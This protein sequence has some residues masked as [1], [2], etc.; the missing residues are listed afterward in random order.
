MYTTEFCWHAL[1]RYLRSVGFNRTFMFGA[2]T[3]RPFASLCLLCARAW[4]ETKENRKEE[5][6]RPA[7]RG[8]AW[9]KVGGSRKG[10][11]HAPYRLTSGI[12]C[13]FEGLHFGVCAMFIQHFIKGQQ[14]RV[15]LKRCM[16]FVFWLKCT[17]KLRLSFLLSLLKLRV[18][19]VETLQ[20]RSS[21]R[22]TRARRGHARFIIHERVAL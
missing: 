2:Y 1:E 13:M 3:F 8:K 10:K 14:S 17:S 4:G 16:V 9:Q 15:W 20:R 5:R 22:K 7:E 6:M 12:A 18:L 11:L 19:G 21:R